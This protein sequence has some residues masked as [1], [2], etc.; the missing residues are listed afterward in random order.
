MKLLPSQTR[1]SGWLPPQRCNLTTIM[2]MALTVVAVGCFAADQK[3]PEKKA[4]D[5]KTT[6]GAISGETANLIR[7]T[8]A[9]V[10]ALGEAGRMCTVALGKNQ[11]QARELQAKIQELE[12]RVANLKEDLN[13]LYQTRAQRPPLDNNTEYNK[14]EN[15][16][17]AA[18][19]LAT[20]MTA[21][22]AKM[23][24]DT[25]K[26]QT[27][28]NNVAEFLRR[29]INDPSQTMLTLTNK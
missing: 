17:K 16:R 4:D 13:R 7:Q 27:C 24:S 21:E 1:R 25:L 20:T 11:S 15:Q 5:P 6:I 9:K 22:L 8:V 26:Q 23:N 10:T 18:Q 19:S 2:K 14:L 28:I 29:I 3:A 12:T